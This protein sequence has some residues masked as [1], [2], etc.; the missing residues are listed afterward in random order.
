MK[1][2]FLL[3]AVFLLP[4]QADTYVRGHMKRDGTYVQ[5][6]MRSSPNRT[7]LDNYSTRG[8]K[9]PYTGSKGSRA[10]DYSPE[11]HSYGGGRPIYTGPRGGRYYIN[12]AGKK[13]YVP[14]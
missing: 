2:L 3:L 4:A 1:W 11:A 14:K 6:H 9:N 8:N 10:Q 12:D 5:G 7:N 13:V